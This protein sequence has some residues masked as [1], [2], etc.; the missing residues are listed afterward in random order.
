MTHSTFAEPLAMMFSMN[1]GQTTMGLDGQ[2]VHG[3][4]LMD[5]LLETPYD[6]KDKQEL[7]Q[8]CKEQYEDNAHELAILEEF[9]THYHPK[10][11]L[12]WYTRDSFLYRLL[13]QALRSQNI[14]LIFLFRSICHDIS[15][16]LKKYQCQSRI[17]TY[18]GQCMELNEIESLQQNLGQLISINSFL[19]TTL[20]RQAV[21]PF[22]RRSNETSDN[23]KHVLLEISADPS[24]INKKPF[25]DISAH[26]DFA[27]E[28]EVLFM[29]GSIF[30][31]REVI[32]GEDQIWIIR[33]ELSSDSDHDMKD[34]INQ[35]RDDYRHRPSLRA[36]G[37]ILRDMGQLDLAETYLHRLFDE[38]PSNDPLR[39]DLC[40]DLSRIASMKKD[41]DQ[42]LH[43][44]KKM[45]ES[46][47]GRMMI[48][49]SK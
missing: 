2:F 29:F 26:S 24:V 3:Q 13:N 38:L 19:S 33:L 31:V 39:K 5:I 21:L 45:M 47:S 11:A 30:R 22:L 43:W 44:K 46:P 16:N 6:E 7:I 25:A 37:L 42:S 15:E 32:Q 49:L 40:L 12:W 17:Q 36:L 28:A 35:M 23:V 27:K 8:L 18:R 14:H 34:V 1:N 4:V 10:K 9:Q 20:D 48:F 41:F